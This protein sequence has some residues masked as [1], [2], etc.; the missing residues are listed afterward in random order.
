M[1]FDFAIG[2]P[3]YNEDFENSGDNGNFAKPVY[4]I[5]MDEANK[6]ADRVELVTPARFLFNA[7]ST[8]KSWNEKMLTD[9]HFKVLSYE[10]DSSKIFSNTDIKGGIAITYRDAAK[11]YGEIGTFV[12]FEELR[13]VL[14]KVKNEN[15]KSFADLVYPRTLY[16]FTDKLYEENEWAK[17]RPSKGHLYDMSSNSFDIFPELFF[18]EKPNDGEEYAKLFGLG[19]KKRTYKWIKL[20]YVKVPDNFNS[21]KVFVPAANGS[22][23]IGEV[24]STPV[25]GQP[26]IGHTETF[27]SIGKF[28]TS[29]A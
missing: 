13:S 16:R 3:P 23:A 2:N 9:P 6:V 26:V 28:D 24:L 20:S 8:P 15:F 4:N 29:R 12:V 17:S 10:A 21:Y 7:G 22:G 1:K 25:I 5:F 11:D 27:L 18:D 14:Q 19:N